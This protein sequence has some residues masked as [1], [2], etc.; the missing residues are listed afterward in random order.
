MNNAVLHQRPGLTI[1]N[2][3]L[4]LCVLGLVMVTS[5]SM[6]IAE[7]QFGSPWY[8]SLRHGLYLIMAALA[9]AIVWF[10]PLQ[11]W[12]DNHRLV[13]FA[14]LL[15]L[16]LVLIPGIGIETN[17]SRRWIGLPGFT[18]Q[19][20]ELFKFSFVVYL[21]ALLAR[22]REVLAERPNTLVAHVL[23]L[24]SAPTVLILMQPDFGSVV[25]L[26][27][28]LLLLLF[29]AGLSIARWST[30]IGGLFGLGLLAIVNQSYRWDRVVAFWNPWAERH[31]GGYQL[32]QS[33]IALGRGG[34]GGL[35]LGNSVQKLSYLPE[36]HTDFVFAVTA[37]EL[38]FVGAALIVVLFMAL[39]LR[40]FYLGFRFIKANRYFAGLFMAGS[41]WMLGAQAFVN[42]G[43][44]IGLLPTKG[45]TLPLV[46]YGGNSLIV[47]S[48]LVGALLGG[49]MEYAV[50][51]RNYAA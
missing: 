17:G 29:L 43:V 18:L 16:V 25:L 41:A 44:N 50:R 8:Y 37:E 19:P 30:L 33:L 20:A 11:F 3:W 15:L 26:A 51:S 35:G 13:F 36:A 24:V 39:A 22:K 10:L 12:Y 34:W 27:T 7:D 6:G 21:S 49:E 42:I 4:A 31:D 40:G 14:T 48:L 38:G 47:S 32:V 45:L 46:S 28:T 2:I 5:T 1:F 9:M 23:L